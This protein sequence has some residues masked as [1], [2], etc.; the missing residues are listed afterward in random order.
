MVR[1]TISLWFYVGI[2]L[3]FYG[4][5]ILGAGIYQFSHPP[6]PPLVLQSLH[7]GVWWGGFLFLA[8]L[9]Y[10][11]VFRPGRKSS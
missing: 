8:G 11:I 7:A 2:L 4:A 9:M 6:Q 3:T 1:S 5:L 10:L